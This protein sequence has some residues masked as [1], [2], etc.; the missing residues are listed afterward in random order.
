MYKIWSF[1]YAKQGIFGHGDVW[2]WGAICADTKLVPCWH[3]GSRDAD[4]AKSFMNDL[5]G[6]LTQRVQLTTDGHKVYLDAVVGAFGPDVDYARFVKL[7]GPAPEQEKRYSPSQCNGT[8]RQKING[9]PTKPMYR[10]ALSS[11]RI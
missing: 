4:S 5:A 10:L 9:N 8:K 11:A 7:Y 6:R 1:V 2:A 3:V